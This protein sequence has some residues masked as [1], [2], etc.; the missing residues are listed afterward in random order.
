MNDIIVRTNLRK[1]WVKF[2]HWSATVK[3]E[4]VNWVDFDKINVVNPGGTSRQEIWV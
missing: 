4:C 2:P 1:A 3:S